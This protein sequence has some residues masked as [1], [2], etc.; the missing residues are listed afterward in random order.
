MD[1]GKIGIWFFLDAM[2]APESVAVAAQPPT[3]TNSSDT[4]ARA[5]TMSG[6]RLGSGYSLSVLGIVM[7]SLPRC[8]R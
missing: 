7:L 8:C 1:I 2:T 3:P 4:V 6:R 5:V